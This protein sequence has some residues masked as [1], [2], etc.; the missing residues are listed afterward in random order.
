[1]PRARSPA[2]PASSA[3]SAIPDGPTWRERLPEVIEAGVVGARR[4]RAVLDVVAAPRRR[5]ARRCRPSASRAARISLSAS[6]RTSRIAFQKSEHRHAALLDVPHAGR[7]GAA[8]PGH[9]RHLTHALVGIGHERDHEARQRRVERRV[10]PRQRF[11]QRLRARRRRGRARGTPR[12]TAASDRQRRRCS[13]PARAASSAVSPPG[14][15]PT[16]RTRVP[17][18]HRRRRTSRPPASRVATHEAVVVLG[19]RGEL[20][21]ARP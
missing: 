16:S 14:P 15:Q 4:E 6:G 19:G 13:A 3:A 10:V 20:H 21:R 18:A 1:M 7:D 2:R 11:R 8:G 9:A 17:A 12:R 5:S